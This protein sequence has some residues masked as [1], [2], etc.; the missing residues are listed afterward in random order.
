MNEHPEI[1]SNFTAEQIIGDMFYRFPRLFRGEHVVQ[2]AADIIFCVLGNGYMWHPNGFPYERTIVEPSGQSVTIPDF[3]R[4][5]HWYP[6]SEYAALWQAATGKITL[7]DSFQKLAKNVC[8]SI[9]NHGVPS[10]IHVQPAK[11]LHWAKKS[12]AGLLERYPE[13]T[14]CKI[15]LPQEGS[16]FIKQH[17][18][19]PGHGLIS[20]CIIGSSN[21]S[22]CDTHV[23]GMEVEK[24]FPGFESGVL[25]D[26]NQR[27]D[28]N[29]VVLTFSAYT[30]SIPADWK[31]VSGPLPTN[32]LVPPG[33]SVPAMEQPES[34]RKRLEE[35]TKKK[36]TSTWPKCGVT[37]THNN[38]EGD[39]V[40]RENWDKGRVE[41]LVNGVV[42]IGNSDYQSVVEQAQRRFGLSDSV[43]MTLYRDYKDDYDK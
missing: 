12:L 39:L 16:I 31:A 5:H 43:L 27:T 24:D 37:V 28:D 13:S 10:S 6:L 14:G 3:D 9:I 4:Q 26:A 11:Q 38:A 19:D 25:C 32:L 22:A 30:D 41:A 29:S 40:F 33:L 7:N 15:E 23:L 2:K 34:L 21:K 8:R 20:L 1:K 18:P 36:Q 17:Y 42:V 35:K